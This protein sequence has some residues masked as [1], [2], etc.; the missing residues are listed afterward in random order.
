MQVMHPLEYRER[1][2]SIA[3]AR[4]KDRTRRRRANEPDSSSSSSSSDSELGDSRDGH[5]A[6]NP[7]DSGIIDGM[8][9]K[10]AANRT[11]IQESGSK[12]QCSLIGLP[13]F[14]FFFYRL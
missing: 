1:A 8:P 12:S 11:R 7:D 4:L 5:G 6:Q 9:W 2:F 3:Q 10:L 13:F 14:F